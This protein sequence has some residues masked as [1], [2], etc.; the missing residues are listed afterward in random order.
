MPTVEKTTP[1]TVVVHGV[2]T[3]EAGTQKNVDSDTAEY[4]TGERGGFEYV[5]DGFPREED[6]EDVEYVE[7]SEDAT[8]AS[9]SDGERSREE[10][11]EQG[12]CPWCVEDGAA[13]P[14]QGDHIGQHA[15][16]AHP[17][18]WDAYQD[19]GSE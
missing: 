6:A 14:Y 10:L 16:S 17:D 11:I 3:F 15:S 4:L 8:E 12:E 5:N 9:E 13:D 1:G 7:S 19:G 2:G 18:E